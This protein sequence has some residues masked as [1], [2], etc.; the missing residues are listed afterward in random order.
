VVAGGVSAAIKA[1]VFVEAHLARGD[2]DG[3]SWSVG[4]RLTY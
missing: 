1:G 3:Q 4:A 2:R